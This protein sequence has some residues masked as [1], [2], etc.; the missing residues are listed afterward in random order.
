MLYGVECWPTKTWR[1]QVQQISV[2]E[3]YMLR[4]ICGHTKMD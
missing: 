3:I 4:W 1:V 2:A